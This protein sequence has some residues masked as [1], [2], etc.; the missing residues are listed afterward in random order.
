[1]AECCTELDGSSLLYS[2]L[3]VGTETVME[4]L[5]RGTTYNVVRYVLSKYKTK[6]GDL[7]QIPGGRCTED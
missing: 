6:Q 1:M 3:M 2:S 7:R 4:T 5:V